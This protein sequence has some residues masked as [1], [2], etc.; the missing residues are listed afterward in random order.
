MMVMV[1]M[2]RQGLTTLG[3]NGEREKKVMVMAYFAEGHFIEEKE[4]C[5]LHLVFQCSF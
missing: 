4:G 3:V 1:M 5:K 2:I